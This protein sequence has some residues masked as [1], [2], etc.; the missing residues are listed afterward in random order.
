[1]PTQGIPFPAPVF[2]TTVPWFNFSKGVL[3]M[4]YRKISVRL[5]NDAKVMSLSHLVPKT[6]FGNAPCTAYPADPETET[7]Q[8]GKWM[9]SGMTVTE[10]A[11][12]FDVNEN[13]GKQ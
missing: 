1:M 12:K 3:L 4:K 10:W 6:D 5:W 8:I 13:G 7:W 2:S 11:R 9:A